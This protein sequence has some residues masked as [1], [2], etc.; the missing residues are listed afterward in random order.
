M[1]T[2]FWVLLVAL[3]PLAA[4]GDDDGGPADGGPGDAASADAAAVDGGPTGPPQMIFE[5]SSEVDIWQRPFPIETLRTADGNP[6]MAGFPNPRRLPLL[7]TFFE[8]IET[9]VE[10]WSPTGPTWFPFDGPLDVSTLPEDPA[11]Y[12]DDADAPIVLV[13]IDPDSPERGA[14]SPLLVAFAESDRDPYRPPNLLQVLPA[15]GFNLREGTLYGVVVRD[16]EAADPDRPIQQNPVL[17]QLLAGEVPA[18]DLGAGLA[19]DW[20]PLRSWLDEEGIDAGTILAAT[21]YRTGDVT[22]R[23]HAIAEWARAQPAPEPSVAPAPLLEMPEYCAYLGAWDPPQYQAGEPPYSMEGG[24][25]VL[26]EDGAPVEQRSERAPFV[27]AVPKGEMPAEGWP[28]LFYMNGTG[29][30]ARQVI[31]RGRATAA[32]PPPAGTGPAQIAAQR[33]WGASGMAGILTPERLS[34]GGLGGYI[35]YNFFNPVAMR[36]NFRQSLVE[37]MFFRRL[38]LELRIDPSTCEGVD[39]SAAE[40]GL[41]RYDPEHLVVMGQSLGSYLTG[42]LATLDPGWDGAIFTGAG[43][44][45]IEFPFGARSPDLTA[46]ARTVLSVT[47]TQP[48]DRFHPGIFLFDLAVGPSDNTH[49]ADELLRN[50]TRDG[51]REGFDPPHVLVI[52][53]DD[54]DNISTGLQRALNAALG[55]DLVGMDVGAPEDRIEPWIELRGRMRRA[56]PVRANV[57]TSAGARTAGVVRWLPDFDD[58]GHYVTFQLDGPKRQYGCFLETLLSDPEGVPTIFAGGAADAPCE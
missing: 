28:L 21:V 12:R 46:L 41:V 23:M 22:S 26:D 24:N 20:A 57:M 40:D 48:F 42:M 6:S 58:G 13:D 32:G 45:W 50:P 51:Q 54:D 55:T 5:P 3:A 29:G 36:D 27:I 25:M 44:S 14:R 30:V 1:R 39:A 15:P 9:E 10:G 17:G 31:D 37:H 34:E 33:G 47:G 43:G 4:C 52:E 49:Y 2:R 8:T 53:G 19:A 7:E 11:A 35:F 56:P 16:L 38:L 18:G